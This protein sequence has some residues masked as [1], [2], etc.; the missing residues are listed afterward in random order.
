[1]KITFV[2]G[3]YAKMPRGGHL[4][5][6]NYASHLA[7]RGHEVT[8]IHPRK[9]P[10]YL[11]SLY[12]R[13]RRKLGEKRDWFLTPNRGRQF[14]RKEVKMIYVPDLSPRNIP[15]GDIVFATAWHTASSVL[16]YPIQ[17][18]E[19]FYLIQGYETWAGPKEAV[20]AT[21]RTQLHK[22]VVAS[23][24][25]KLGI[26]L[27]CEDIT[28]I[29]N[30]IEHQ[31][32]RITNPIETRPP[33]IAF[34][35]SPDVAKGADDALR[36]LTWVKARNEKLEAR[37]F[38]TC[39]RPRSIPGWIKYYRN[40]QRTELTDVIF[41]SSSIYLASSRSEGFP[42]SPAEAMACGC[43]LVSTDIPGIHEYAENGVTA[44]LSPVGNPRAL[45]ESLL[46]IL[47]N[48]EL[49]LKLAIAGC[50]RV[51]ELTWERSTEL[52]EKL[53]IGRSRFGKRE[54]TQNTG[55][56]IAK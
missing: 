1:M 5:V 44:L 24:L 19:K 52:L 26:E 2:Q 55:S 12:R 17:K 6:Y 37:F 30:G 42:L 45:A 38:G 32:F 53:L 54:S 33:R 4:V 50:Q 46:C 49:R 21:W 56:G 13:V 31:I 48:N 25:Y 20:D 43:A 29:P 28:Y 23:W 41:N 10:I 8:V 47:D 11:P 51:Q 3:D 9:V 18:G 14:I 16:Q 36:A 34:L 15:D 40:V 7:A 39:A 35:Y 27:G 22:V